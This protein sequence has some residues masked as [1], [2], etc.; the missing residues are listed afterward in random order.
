MQ[1]PFEG[2]NMI[3][4]AKRIVMDDVAPI[5]SYYSKELN[6]IIMYSLSSYRQMFVKDNKKRITAEQIIKKPYITRAI[7][8]FIK[9]QGNLQELAKPIKLNNLNG[10]PSK[11]AEE[12]TSMQEEEDTMRTIKSVVER[13]GGS[14]TL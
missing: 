6:E 12:S 3:V 4:L 1:Y 11:K 5:P 10:S 7:Q 9:E 13:T 2:P 14:D 8:E